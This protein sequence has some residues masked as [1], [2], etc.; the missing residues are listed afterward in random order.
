MFQLVACSTCRRA[1][2]TERGRKQATCVRC[3]RTLDLQ[4]LRAFLV[5]TSLEGAQQAAGMLNARLA[6]REAEYAQALILPARPAPRHD[7]RFA[8]AAAA[9]RTATSEKDRADA[10]ARALREFTESD[11]ALAFKMTGLPAAKLETQ[12]K[13]MLATDVV[14]QP[15]TGT[16]RIL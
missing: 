14:F 4:N 13:R 10:I 8:A 11:L 6:G 3:S 9:A 2:V 12:L 15:R 5:T 16:Y 1:Q 7:D